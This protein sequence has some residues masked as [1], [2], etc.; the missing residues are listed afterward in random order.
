[1]TQRDEPSP[2]SR[3]DPAKGALILGGAHGSLEIARSLGRRG[4]R[5]W[6]ITDDNLLAK[7]S[8]YVER[9]LT[10]AGPRD[11]GALSFLVE[12]CHRDDLRGWVL[13]A[14]SD[15]DLRFVAQNH[16]TLSGLFALTTQAWDAVRWAYDKRQMNTRAAELG[17]A[18][19]QSFY[20]RTHDDVADIGLTFPVILKPTVREGRNA[21]VDAKAWRVDHPRD[22]PGRYEAA[23]AL[24]GADA[25]MIQELI[26]GAGTA[27]YSYA[28]VCVR[29]APVGTLVA[30]RR[31]QYPVEFGFTSTF[32]ETLDA[33]DIEAAAARFLTSLNYSGLVEI[34]FKYDA[35]DGLYKVLDVNAR[36][37]T[38]IALGTAAGID[39]AAIQWALAMGEVIAPLT[40]RK[41]VSWLYFPRD[42]VASLHEIVAGRLSPIDYLRS[43]RHSSASAVFAWDDP[44]PAALDIPL[45]AVRVMTRRL[46]RRSRSVAAALQSARLPS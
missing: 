15:D 30:R 31:R 6:L 35:R 23:K 22:L 24:V 5:V 26:P 21:F 29:G 32:V 8:R 2:V 33:L 25:I 42:L 3:S 9:S 10:W 41:S 37:W 17:M 38:W 20:P 36:A 12:L 14:G 18:H 13:F 44:W 19:P 43:L 40:A 11:D 34:E 4:I 7:L 27:Q 16:A 39:F 28:A 1:M 45:S 46:S